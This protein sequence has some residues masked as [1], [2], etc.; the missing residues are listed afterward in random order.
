MAI[1]K[2]AKTYFKE[3]SEAT[4]YRKKIYDLIVGTARG[5]C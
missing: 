5:W 4:E 3:A 2:V 1:T